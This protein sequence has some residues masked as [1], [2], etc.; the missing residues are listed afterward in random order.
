MI[1]D[2]KPRELLYKNPQSRP[3]SRIERW[4]LRLQEYSFHIKYRPGSKNPSDYLSRHPLPTTSTPNPLE[5]IT[6]DHVR[7]ITESALPVAMG[8]ECVRNATKQ[9]PTLSKVIKFIEANNWTTLDT[10][11][12]IPLGIIIDELHALML[13]EPKL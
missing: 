2:K 7:L 1:T 12:E 9:D 8:I 13:K 3:S 10:P 6:E 5:V 4:C 11:E